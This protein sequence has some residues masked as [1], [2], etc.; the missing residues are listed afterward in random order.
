MV[1]PDD[2]IK[3]FLLLFFKNL[4]IVFPNGY[5]EKLERLDALRGMK[6]TCFLF[7]K[8]LDDDLSTYMIN[9]WTSYRKG[10]QERV[11]WKV[12][13]PNECKV[14]YVNEIMDYLGFKLV[15]KTLK[16]EVIYTK[17]SKRP[18]KLKCLIMRFARPVKRS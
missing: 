1:E 8:I 9:F 12:Y 2:D 3:E 10:N 4:K 17:V 11:T 18:H 13:F 15:S 5:E 7:R 14:G 6:A 16:D